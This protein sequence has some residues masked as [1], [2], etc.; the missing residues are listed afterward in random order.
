MLVLMTL[1]QDCMYATVL[2]FLHH[3]TYCDIADTSE[4]LS[5]IH[6]HSFTKTYDVVPQVLAEVLTIRMCITEYRLAHM[7]A[8]SNL[9]IDHC[10]KQIT[11]YLNIFLV[12]CTYYTNSMVSHFITRHVAGGD[13]TDEHTH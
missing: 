11:P 1:V 5:I 12:K 6:V 10:G 2:R 9:P 3:T 13:V 8:F 7:H 4:S